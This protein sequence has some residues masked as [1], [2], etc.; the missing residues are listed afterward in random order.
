MKKLY[1]I[2]E[3][4]PQDAFHNADLTGVIIRG[5]LEEW[6][7]EPGWFHGHADMNLRLYCPTA[8]EHDVWCTSFYMIKVTPL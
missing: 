1:M 3:V 2:T 5:N 7:T 4:H 6:E 8:P